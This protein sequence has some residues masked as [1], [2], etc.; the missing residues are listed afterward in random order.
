MVDM[1]GLVGLP[2]EFATEER[3]DC[4]LERGIGRRAPKLLREALLSPLDGSRLRECIKA[5]V[6]PKDGLEAG[7]SMVFPSS[8]GTGR[9]CWY[10]EMELW[11]MCF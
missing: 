11:L 5:S 3:R 9:L 4:R 2:S 1:P 7:T 8:P 10:L 6:W